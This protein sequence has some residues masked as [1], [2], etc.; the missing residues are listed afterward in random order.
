MV[1]KIHAR[2]ESRKTPGKKFETTTYKKGGVTKKAKGGKIKKM[3]AGG[4]MKQGYN[5]RLD[6]SL[7]AR[8][9]GARGSMAGRRAESQGME[10]ALGHGAYSGAATMAKKGG[11]ISKKMHGG[12]VHKKK[13]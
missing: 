8:H 5:A 11:K 7:G 13:K 10:R 4:P 3:Q 6:D 12:K 2:R 1:G 9:P